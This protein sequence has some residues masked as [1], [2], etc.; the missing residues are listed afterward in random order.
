MAGPSSL[1]GSGSLEVKRGRVVGLG[2]AASWRGGRLQQGAKPGPVRGP[3]AGQS[4]TT[5]LQRWRCWS[6]SPLEAGE[7]RRDHSLAAERPGKGGGPTSRQ[8]RSSGRRLACLPACCHS[9]ALALGKGAAAAVVAWERVTGA[10]QCSAGRDTKTKP[11][12]E[13]AAAG[14]WPPGQVRLGR[15]RRCPAAEES[16]GLAS[17]RG[18]KRQAPQGRGDRLPANCSSPQSGSMYCQTQ[19]PSQLPPE[20]DWPWG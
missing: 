19:Q 5:S 11:A 10:A 8:A 4:P 7:T 12:M 13:Q 20:A 9:P 1:V 17:V 18:D 6:D 3:S 14:Q 16:P 2:W 15:L